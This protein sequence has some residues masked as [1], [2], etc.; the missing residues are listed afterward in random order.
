[1][2]CGGVVAPPFPLCRVP[3]YVKIRVGGLFSTAWGCLLQVALIVGVAALPI[4]LAAG[5]SMAP[6]VGFSAMDGTRAGVDPPRVQA[7]SA[8]WL[9]DSC[10]DPVSSSLLR[11]LSYRS[12]VWV[13]VQNEG[14]RG[15]PLT[16]VLTPPHAR[17][18]SKTSA[19]TSPPW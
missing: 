10:C 9:L 16:P 11:W 18:F 15:A 6:S 8:V 7:Y 14:W 3:G 13:L 2:V 12:Y 1:M 19:S 4:P 5:G 17:S